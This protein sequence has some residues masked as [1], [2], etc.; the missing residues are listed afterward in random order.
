LLLCFAQ[1]LGKVFSKTVDPFEKRL[2]LI[3]QKSSHYSRKTAFIA[4]RPNTFQRNPKNQ[5]LNAIQRGK[6][7]AAEE[8]AKQQR[9]QHQPLSKG[10]TRVLLK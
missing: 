1:T 6:T 5:S 10:N 7:T 4:P 9:L 8:G 2:D 3:D